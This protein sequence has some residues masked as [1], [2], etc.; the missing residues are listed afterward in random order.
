MLGRSVLLRGMRYRRGHS[1]MVLLLALLCA[2]AAAITPA[3]VRAAQQ[4]VV[5]DVIGS[6]PKPVTALR[7][8]TNA[9]VGLSN[10]TEA[11]ALDGANALLDNTLATLPYLKAHVTAGMSFTRMSF[12]LSGVPAGTRVNGSLVYRAGICDELVIEGQCPTAPGEVLVSK[13]SADLH[14]L[15]AAL[16]FARPLMDYQ[17][18][19]L[20][21]PKIVGTYTPKDSDAD[22][23]AFNG[24]LGFTPKPVILM[25]GTALYTL[26]AAFT[27]AAADIETAIGQSS[28]HVVRFLNLDGVDT[29]QMGSL[30][31]ELEAFAKI[32][33]SKMSF[34]SGLPTLLD[35]V[36]RDQEAIASGVP[37]GAVPLLI[38]TLAVLMLLVAALTEDRGA[39]IALAKLHGYSASRMSWFGLGEVLVLI[40]IAAPLGLALSTGALNFAARFWLAPGTPLET[41]WQPFAAVGISLI[42]AY[43]A[44]FAAS[45]RLIRGQIL[46]LLRRVP[47]RAGWRASAMEGAL[48]AFALAV[49]VVTWQD[50]QSTLAT[51]AAPSVAIVAGV[52]GGRMLG[53]LAARGLVKMRRRA[54]VTGLVVRAQ[55]ARRAGRQRIVVMVSVAAALIAFSALTWDAGALARRADAAG[56]AGAAK[57]YTV[58]A[59]DVAGLVSA[60][61]AAAPDGTAMAVYRRQTEVNGE[62]VQV[63][64]VQ[65]NLLAKVVTWPGRS[66]AEISEVAAKLR[67]LAAEPIRVSGRFTLRAQATGF[68]AFPAE[69]AVVVKNGPEVTQV[70][71][72]RLISGEHDY[73]ATVP[74]GQLVS[75]KIL[76]PAA[77]PVT[78]TGSVTLLQ[79]SSEA[80]VN[81]PGGA[82]AWQRPVSPDIQVTLRGDDRV[83]AEITA[84]GY[85]DIEIVHPEVP[86]ALPAVLLGSIPASVSASGDWVFPAIG[87]RPQ[88][89]VVAETTTVLP[90]IRGHGFMSDLDY[91]LRL[92]L[93]TDRDQAR[94]AQAIFYEVWAGAGAPED[95]PQ[96]LMAQGLEI[97]GRRTLAAYTEQLERR[98][99]AL[100]LRFSLIAG[101]AGVLLALG[102]V[103]LMS[104]IGSHQ[105]RREIAALRVAG[106][107]VRA[108]HR[109]LRREY[110]VLIG[111][112]SA[113]GFAV[114]IGTALMLIPGMSLVNAGVT[115]ITPIQLTPAITAAYAAAGMAICCAV[116]PAWAAARLMGRAAPELLRSSDVI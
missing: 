24:L 49:L 38:L 13:R 110:L 60:V 87:V 91:G 33:G 55:L 106:V 28:K 111:L 101:L 77:N 89:F 97:T 40:T 50:R 18:Q 95:L 72:G 25:D 82:K 69:L 46:H 114:G 34:H 1:A 3:Y 41:R 65:S 103:A 32:V 7:A 73:T 29:D 105:R 100:T 6:A 36:R 79:V 109:S 67:P 42:A 35:E 15:G 107:P 94:G 88:P 20:P 83:E 99:P 19:L 66:P 48:I 84:T 64:G 9:G 21:V 5:R 80:G 39:E 102:I 43:V 12:T 86:K 108:L 57:V 92:A 45:R 76:R 113:L 8:D 93:D 71:L 53:G 115:A 17:R 59:P 62:T 37:M 44:A 31:T 10:F 30:R 4:S 16:S 11:S 96:R 70:P 27:A 47:Q 51:L 74:S 90:G 61:S 63:I 85:S 68:A 56:M 78:A 75:V 116:L 22:H 98:A 23:W 81:S 104:Q 54:N 52:L 112:P 2:A 14:H 26:D 58:L